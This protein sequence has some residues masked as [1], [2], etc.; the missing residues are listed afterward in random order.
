VARLSAT[1]LFMGFS[2]LAY[3]SAVIEY[4]NPADAA[5]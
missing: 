5:L 3:T 4:W 2:H 1:A